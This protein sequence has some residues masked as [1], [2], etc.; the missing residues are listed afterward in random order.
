MTDNISF[1]EST[2]SPEIPR[3][4]SRFHEHLSQAYTAPPEHWLLPTSSVPTPRR[5]HKHSPSMESFASASST[6]STSSV[7]RLIR[8]AFRTKSGVK[9]RTRGA[10]L[11]FE[12]KGSSRTFRKEDI[13]L[14]PLTESSNLLHCK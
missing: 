3:Y 5:T 11:V 10:D 13:K 14:G 9:S 2:E 6:S 8:F 7:D 4:T 1:R 12:I